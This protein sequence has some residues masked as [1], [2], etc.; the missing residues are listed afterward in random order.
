MPAQ[1]ELVKPIVT[2]N[3]KATGLFSQVDDS[4]A[5]GKPL[6][7]VTVNNVPLTD[8]ALRQGLSGQA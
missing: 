4:P 6:L 3:I 7:S 5:P 8:D 2:D 1:P